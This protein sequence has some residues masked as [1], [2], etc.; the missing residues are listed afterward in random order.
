MLPVQ[1]LMSVM[2]W[3][4]QVYWNS[5]SRTYWVHWHMIEILSNG[6]GGQVEKETQEKASSLTETINLTTGDSHTQPHDRVCVCVCFMCVFITLYETCSVFFCVCE[7]GSESDVLLKAPRWAVYTALPDG[8]LSG[9]HRHPEP[10]WMV[11]SGVFHQEVGT[12]AA[13]GDQQHPATEPRW[14]GTHI[15]P[16]L[17]T[18][19]RIQAG[20]TKIQAHFFIKMYSVR[21]PHNVFKKDIKQMI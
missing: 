14:A 19:G 20:K 12:Q 2:F 15:S 3:L 7:R 9:W 8:G 10:C 11:G 18:L 13:A 16:T 1:T 5:L 17:F 6:S 4:L 21:P